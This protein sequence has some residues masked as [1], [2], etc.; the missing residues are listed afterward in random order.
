MSIPISHFPSPTESKHTIL[1][2]NLRLWDDQLRRVVVISA[3]KWMVQDTDGLQ[4]MASNLDFAR[5]VRR[6]S[7]D[8]LRLGLE[9]HGCLS[10]PILHGSLDANSFVT[11]INDLVD[12]GVQ[13]VG[14]SV[15]GRETGKALGQ[16]AETVERVDIGGFAVSRDG[17]S[18]QADAFDGFG[19]LTFVGQVG[20]VLVEGHGMSD[21]VSSSCLEAEFVVDILHCACR[22][23]ET[24]SR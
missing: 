1:P 12:V 18:V 6:I 2:S 23:V 5:E 17:V 20:V 21:E 22:D 3:S 11:I 15:D 13:H 10:A 8:L 16:L 7:E 14:S 24:C 4:D 9:L 19:G